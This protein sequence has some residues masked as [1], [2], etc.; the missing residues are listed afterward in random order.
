MNFTIQMMPHDENLIQQAGAVLTAAMRIN[1]V[2]AWSTVEEGIAE[3]R[4]MLAEERICIVA[5]R[6]KTVLGWIGGIPEYDGNVWELHPLA[7]HPDYQSQGVGTAL[8]QA[9]EQAVAARGGLTIMLGT[10]DENGATTLSDVDL[11]ADITGAISS[12]KTRKQHPLDFYRKL[13]YVIIGVMPD[14]NGIGKPDIYM[15]K[16]IKS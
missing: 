10:D 1:W 16:R 9:L 6:D 4:E 8:V 7:I 14:A 2:E 11:Y 13:G 3:V 15:G 5:L 12:A